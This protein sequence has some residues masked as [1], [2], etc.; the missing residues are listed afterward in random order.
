MWLPVLNV[1]IR[2][3]ISGSCSVSITLY[4]CFLF[5]FMYYFSLPVL[6]FFLFTFQASGVWFV[7]GP[8]T[9]TI[10]IYH[11]NDNNK[12]NIV[13][14]N[15]PLVDIPNCLSLKM[16]CMMKKEAILMA[17]MDSNILPSTDRSEIS[18]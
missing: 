1:S 7:V 10:H 13:N 17:M 8:S 14:T 11:N 3:E 2:L 6:F 5:T 4:I 15:Q 18:R 12:I 9:R 16:R